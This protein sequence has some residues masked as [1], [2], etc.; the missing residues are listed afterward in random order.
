MSLFLENVFET[1]EMNKKIGQI[2]R[3]KTSL[4]VFI[5]APF[6]GT[7]LRQLCISKGYLDPDSEI[8]FSFYK[9]SVLNMPSMSR[10]EIKGLAKTIP[11][12]I[13]LPKTYYEQI[14]VAEQDTAEGNRMFEELRKL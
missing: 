6:S 9:G 7:P 10:E 11:L 14:T 12:Y 13:K 1:I 3:D 5:F 4:N 8:L 2:L